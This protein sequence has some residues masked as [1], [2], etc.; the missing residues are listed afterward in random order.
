MQ[1][2]EKLKTIEIKNRFVNHVDLVEFIK[3]KQDID[4]LDDLKN[5]LQ[6]YFQDS[7]NEDIYYNNAIAYLKEN[8]PGLLQSLKIASNYGYSL[9]KLNSEILASLLQTQNNQEDFQKFL[10]SDSIS[11]IFELFFKK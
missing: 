4:D 1:I 3:S 8:D 6:E 5:K 7:I 2:L 9:E 10:E 11:E